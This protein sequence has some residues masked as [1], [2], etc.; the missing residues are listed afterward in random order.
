[1][2]EKTVEE[3]DWD[4]IRKLTSEQRK[5]NFDRRRAELAAQAVADGGVADVATFGRAV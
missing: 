4:A 2:T 1:M 5:F 3:I